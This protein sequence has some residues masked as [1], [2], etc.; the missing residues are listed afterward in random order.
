[1]IVCPQPQAAEAG[2]AVLRAGGNA[3]DGA[4]VTALVQGVIDPFMCG[5]GGCGVMLLHSARGRTSTVI[6]FYARAGHQVRPHQW[7]D[8]LIREAADRY[9]YVLEGWVN[10][11]GY[12][13]V[14]VPGTVAGLALALQR[15]GT[16]SWAA[17]LKPAIRIA[18]EGCPVT[19]NV[20]GNWLTDSGPD[21]VPTDRR[22]QW[23]A[24]SKRIYTRDGAMYPVG[25][26]IANPD[27]AR[28]LERLAEFG[29]DDFYRGEI[30]AV[31]AADF[32]A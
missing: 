3:V 18:R 6:D 13:S 20:A 10:D 30:A 31:I 27:Y 16:I 15:F 9:G 24:E 5:L 25:E 2:L 32:Q 11:A 23:T 29:A 28:T 26:V 19:G 21:V 8:I 12:Q 7:E 17:A 1:M 14:G 22:L 4:V